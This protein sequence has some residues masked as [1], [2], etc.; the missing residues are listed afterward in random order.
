MSVTVT[1][2]PRILVAGAGP[3]GLMLAGE[4]A[5]FGVACRIVDKAQGRS[6][7]SKAL[8][9]HARTLELWQR[10]GLATAAIALGHKLHGLSIFS[11]GRRIVHVTLDAIHSRFNYVLSIPQSTTEKLLEDRLIRRGGSVER[12]TELVR[13]EQDE[14]GVR[15]LLRSTVTGAERELAADWVIGCDGGHSA[16]RQSLDVPFSGTRLP[17]IF[18]L[19][20]VQLTGN[21]PRDEVVVNLGGGNIFGLIPINGQ[22]MFRLIME[23]RE[24]PSQAHADPTL[25]EFQQILAEYGPPGTSI[26]DPVWLSRFRISQRQ[27]AQYRHG[28]VFLAGDAAHIHSPVGGQGMNTGIQDACNLAWKLALVVQ[29]RGRPEILDSYQGERHPVGEQL[30]RATGAMTRVITW[31]NPVSDAIRDVVAHVATSFDQV[32]DKIR[33][34]VSEIGIQY[35]RSSLVAESHAS[36]AELVAGWLHRHTAVRAGDR[37]PDVV[38]H[39]SGGEPVGLLDLLSGLRPVLLLFTGWRTGA[40]DAARREGLLKT[41]QREFAGLLD[42][43]T[44]VPGAAAAGKHDRPASAP[45]IPSH[46]APVGPEDQVLDDPDSSAHRAFGADDETLLLVRPDGYIGL[47]SQPAAFEPLAAYLRRIFL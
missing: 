32:Q 23:H 34:A 37:A 40:T 17:G 3:T 43:L 2:E 26:S 14:Q 35:R 47:R 19:A 4:L 31:R 13:V 15:A 10:D 5:R 20:D 29:G 16:V 6:K 45:P 42:M 28:R 25:E 11:D 18:S 30:L 24:E 38:L 46:P 9:V 36:A 33:T 7:H 21:V 41:V 39:R 1:A 27:V 22:G 12:N 44:V 8:A